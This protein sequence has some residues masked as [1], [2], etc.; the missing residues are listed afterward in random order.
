MKPSRRSFIKTLLALPAIAKVY[1]KLPAS[2]DYIRDTNGEPLTYLGSQQKTQ[3]MEVKNIN[4]V[5]P[6][7]REEY[8]A[9][10]EGRDSLLRQELRRRTAVAFNKKVDDHIPKA[11][12]QS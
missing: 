1:E 10:F 2:R 6:Q 4:W 12:T 5:T 11:L 3:Q 7:Y 8:I 9:A